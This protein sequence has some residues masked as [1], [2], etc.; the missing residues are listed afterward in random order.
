MGKFK[1]GGV[2]EAKE[3][4]QQEAEQK[5]LH[6]KHKIDDPNT[7]IVEKSNMMKFLIRCAAG[8]VRV[9]ASTAVLALAAAGVVTLVYPEIRREFLYVLKTILDQI[10][11]MIGF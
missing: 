5:N 8:S 9:I 6:I 7:V 4:L 10:R 2:R 1:K 11:N 3:A